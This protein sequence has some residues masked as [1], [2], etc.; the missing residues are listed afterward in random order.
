MR[1]SRCRHDNRIGAKFYEEC[2]TPL[3]RTCVGCGTSKTA[4]E[5]ERKLVTPA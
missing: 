4:L 1:C 2:A 5:S 3:A